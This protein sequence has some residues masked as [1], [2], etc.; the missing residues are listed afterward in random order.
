[1]WNVRLRK[2]IRLRDGR[3]IRTLGDARYV[4]LSLPESDQRLEKWRHVGTLLL[5]AVEGASPALISIVTD[6][7][8]DA[9][10]F[11]PFSTARL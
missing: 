11:P 8:E 7:L 5:R 4:I 10:R 9:L 1:M 3:T 6:R 2:P